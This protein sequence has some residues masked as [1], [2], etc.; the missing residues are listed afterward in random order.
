M[1][2]SLTRGCPG[3]TGSPSSTSS[4]CLGDSGMCGNYGFGVMRCRERRTVSGFVT[5]AGFFSGASF[6]RA[7]FI[8]INDQVA[9]HATG[10]NPGRLY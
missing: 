6:P 3:A 7:C 2:C 4:R 9:G 5:H 10:R 8:R 1:G